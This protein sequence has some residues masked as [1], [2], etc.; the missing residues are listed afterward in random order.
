LS[1]I[2]L[3]QDSKTGEKHQVWLRKQGSRK[4]SLVAMKGNEKTSEVSFK[5]R[6][7]T[8]HVLSP[9]GKPLNP[10]ELFQTGM[11]DLG[12]RLQ[13]SL[14]VMAK[15]MHIPET[16]T[17]R[18]CQND[19]HWWEGV[20]IRVGFGED[21]QWRCRGCDEKIL[22]EKAAAKRAAAKEAK[23]AKKGADSLEEG[24]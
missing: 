21:Y 6:N 9:N 24:R 13:K 18:R 11:L 22:T 16:F 3:I 2:H 7:G 14:D 19:F 20:P 12:L 10:D 5:I 8:I 15:L 4:F 1:P 23:E 17:C